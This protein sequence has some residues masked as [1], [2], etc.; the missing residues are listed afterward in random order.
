MID[1]EKEYV[2][3]KD[4]RFVLLQRLF[5]KANKCLFAHVGA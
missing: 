5:A 1:F 4:N 2:F 3:C